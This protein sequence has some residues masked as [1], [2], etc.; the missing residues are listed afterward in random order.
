MSGINTDGRLRI[1][2]YKYPIQ[3]AKFNNKVEKDSWLYNNGLSLTINYPV[4]KFRMVRIQPSWCKPLWA[5][6]MLCEVGKMLPSINFFASPSFTNIKW[7]L[8]AQQKKIEVKQGETEENLS[9]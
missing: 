8:V 1:K 9:S 3:L 7:Y 2:L 5:T 6:C 4:S